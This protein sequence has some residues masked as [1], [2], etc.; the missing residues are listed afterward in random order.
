[1][2]STSSRADC[3]ARCVALCTP[4]NV[5]P[6]RGQSKEPT[7]D[8]FYVVSPAVPNGAGDHRAAR[9]PAQPGEGRFVWNPPT[10]APPTHNGLYGRVLLCMTPYPRTTVVRF[11]SLPRLS[12]FG[13]RVLQG[14]GA[15][16]C[17]IIIFLLGFP[18][19]I[20]SL[21]ETG[22]CRGGLPTCHHFFP[23]GFPD[24]ETGSYV[25]YTHRG[26]SIRGVDPLN[27]VIDIAPSPLCHRSFWFG[28]RPT[29]STSV[30]GSEQ[31]AQ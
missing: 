12:G 15:A 16:N 19:T 9:T 17:V 4:G 29:R 30:P 6:Q 8:K 22:S 31:N 7:L 18:A 13:N 20:K 27:F 5:G 23:L 24:L 2:R 14:G 3:R 28:S 21:V 10:C 25:C 1:L 26:E 11:F